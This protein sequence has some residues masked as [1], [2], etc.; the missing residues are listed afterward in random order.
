MWLTECW[1]EV[2]GQAV[3]GQLIL[4]ESIKLVI[5][6]DATSRTQSKGSRT[7]ALLW[8]PTSE[9]Q[10]CSRWDTVILAYLLTLCWCSSAMHSGAPACLLTKKM[11]FKGNIKW[12]SCR[13]IC[14]AW[15]GFV[16]VPRIWRFTSLLLIFQKFTKS[17]CVVFFLLTVKKEVD[18][19]LRKM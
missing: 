9:A 10:Q 4:Y 12:W 13:C 14:V 2:F 1:R 8:Q 17:A 5:Q 3:E 16:H 6:V 11:R 7:L 15:M 19:F 18:C